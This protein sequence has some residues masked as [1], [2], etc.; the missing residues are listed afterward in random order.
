M[1]NWEEAPAVYLFTHPVDMRSGFDRL[2]ELAKSELGRSPL[3]GGLFVFVSRNRRRTKIL[4]WEKDGF[5]LLYKR[6]EAGVFHVDFCDGH[7]ELSGVDLKL[8]L[9]GVELSRIRLRKEVD[10][11]LYD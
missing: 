8:L 5:W 7:E 6:L 1:L 9:E 10:K 3:R 2:V 11:G 4:F